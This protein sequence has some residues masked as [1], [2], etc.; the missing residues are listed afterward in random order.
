MKFFGGVIIL[1]KYGINF[2]SFNSMRFIVTSKTFR[3]NFTYYIEK[4]KNILEQ[5]NIVLEDSEEESSDIFD[6]DIDEII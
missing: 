3:S 5:N 6:S 4:F 2:I 1:E